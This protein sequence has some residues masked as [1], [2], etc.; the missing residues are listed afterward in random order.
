MPDTRE[1]SQRHLTKLFHQSVQDYQ[2]AL[3]IEP[4]F[5]PWEERLDADTL[6]PR[7]YFYCP[8]SPNPHYI[9]VSKAVFDDC[10]HE[11]HTAA[12]AQAKDIIRRKLDSLI[13]TGHP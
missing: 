10:A 11:N 1:A 13:K 5:P 7:L 3:K 4:S 8:G 12:L 2:G 6:T 9:R